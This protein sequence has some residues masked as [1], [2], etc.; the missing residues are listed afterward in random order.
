MINRVCTVVFLPL[1]FGCHLGLEQIY[2]L[3]QLIFGQKCLHFY[4]HAIV[5][6]WEE[7]KYCEVGVFQPQKCSNYRE[8][9]P[10]SCPPTPAFDRN[11]IR[12]ALQSVL[13]STTV[14][15]GILNILCYPLY[16]WMNFLS[17]SYNKLY[18]SC[19]WLL[20]VTLDD[21]EMRRLH[22][23]TLDTV[24]MERSVH[25]LRTVLYFLT[26]RFLEC[27]CQPMLWLCVYLF[28]RGMP[29]VYYLLNL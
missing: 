23:A 11:I 14:P 3:C 25:K 5:N 12:R 6:A 4:L 24:Y 26:A 2:P 8:S 15:R 29:P 13:F 28:F 27:M 20:S 18:I 7:S 10:L 16:C 19:L 17:S 9:G 1:L 21:L 22:I